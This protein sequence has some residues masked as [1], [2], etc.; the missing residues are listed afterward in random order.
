MASAIVFAAL[1]FAGVLTRPVDETFGWVL[2]AASVVP[3]AHVV[4]TFRRR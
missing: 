1:L 3:L 2:M 4:A